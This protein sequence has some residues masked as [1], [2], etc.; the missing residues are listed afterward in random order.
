MP[1]ERHAKLFRNGRNQAVR[2]P[3]DDREYG[4]L[5]A[6]LEA[7]GQVIGPNDMLIAAQAIALGCTLVTHN[8]RDFTRVARLRLANWLR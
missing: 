4:A 1:A 7:T 5:R 8:T 2:I 6:A 3:R